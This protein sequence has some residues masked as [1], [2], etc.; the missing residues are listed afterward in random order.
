M[1]ENIS[2]SSFFV[3]FPD[4]LY[5]YTVLSFH[6]VHFNSF[7]PLWIVVSVI[8]SLLLQYATFLYVLEARVDRVSQSRS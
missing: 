3:L 8:P 1:F 5:S 7:F 2:N 4:R 6:L